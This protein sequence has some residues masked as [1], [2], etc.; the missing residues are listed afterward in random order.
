MQATT[1]E[2][3]DAAAASE[4]SSAAIDQ[5]TKVVANVNTIVDKVTEE[6]SRF[7]C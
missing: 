4:E 5:I 1:R 7:K 3:T 2:A 6:V